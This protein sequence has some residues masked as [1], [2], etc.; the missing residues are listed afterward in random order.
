MYVRVLRT[1]E[2]VPQSEHPNFRSAGK[3]VDAPL[4]RVIASLAK[5]YGQAFAS[6]AGLRRLVCEDAGRMA[7]VDTI[8]TALERLEA[9]GIVA[10]RWLRPGGQLPDGN[11]CTRGTRLVWLPQ[12]R[13]DRRAL[14]VVA[15]NRRET[16]SGRVDRKALATFEKARAAIGKTLTAHAP[17]TS[18]SLERRKEEAIAA[19]RELERA[20]AAEPPPEKPPK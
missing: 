7:G 3:M 2:V 15:R 13:H 10:Q 5:K 8:P 4:L 9:R 11:N 19:L 18:A 12:C 14:R 6:E 20:W 1:R 16:V 17:P